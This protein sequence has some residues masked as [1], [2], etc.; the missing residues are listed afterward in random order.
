MAMSKRI[1]LGWSLYV[2]LFIP[3]VLS[4]ESITV[5]IWLFQ[6]I[7][8]AD[9]PRLNKAEFMSFSLQPELSG[10]KALVD[11]PESEFRAAV[12]DTL[13]DMRNLR[14]MD[15]LFLF[16]KTWDGERPILQ[17]TILGNQVAFRVDL[18][19]K[20]VAP[21]QVAMRAVISKTK[22][23]TLH[24]ENNKKKA[25]RDAYEA[26][27]A[28][29]KMERIV[30]EEFFLLIDDPV[31]I[32]VPFKDKGYFLVVQVTTKKP[33]SAR[34]TLA[35]AK[36]PSN[37]NL[38]AASR[39]I[40]TV[41]PFYP[42]ELISQGIKGDIRLRLTIDEK[43]SVQ[44]VELLTHLHPYLDYSAVEAFRL[45]IF[46]PIL[47]KGK[48]VRG[49][50]DYDFT[51]DPGAYSRDI[52]RSVESP[53]D[54]VQPSQN[55]LQGVLNGV[56]GYCRK[57]ADMALFYICEET[58]KEIHRQLRPP[59]EWRDSFLKYR[60]YNRDN[61]YTIVNIWN[62]PVMDPSRSER[63]E[64]ICDYQLI[65]RGAKIDER[66]IV[67]KENGRKTA[68]QNKQLEDSRFSALTPI[69]ASLNFLAQDR[70]PLFNYQ[71]LGE[72]KVRGKA[73]VI[74]E[75]L[76]RSG[77]VDGV[78]SAKVWVDKES[79]QICKCEIEGIPLNGYEDVLR[80]AVLL[81]LKPTFLT[82]HEYRIEK[83][84]VLFPD[85]TT[86]RVEYPI[87]RMQRP[88]LKLKIDLAYRKYK[89]FTVETGHEIKS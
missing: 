34:E 56:A 7:F 67:L 81:N 39:P 15:D 69:F 31:I 89:F 62:V 50:F 17:D 59:R 13:M 9:Q 6:S 18:S 30:D 70:Q 4:S 74:I 3:K 1:V 65:R 47:R 83:N 61:D 33:E 52:I 14:T 12:I 5:R 51:F 8:M 40:H 63:N 38:V 21:L 11:G 27:L 2:L 73:V 36:A 84:R 24:E 87:S 22:D 54:A 53:A 86:V 42:G 44:N 49:A 82:T 45:W 28:D 35:S 23:N 41:L 55:G 88:V 57:L 76:P 85:Q 26:T 77:D 78:R 72:D 64:Y 66:R 79:F 58:I 43:G 19:L 10:L 16:N 25:L 71:I 75:A 20:K 32:G 68:G 37:P 29:S 48:P 80:D 46:E 60:E